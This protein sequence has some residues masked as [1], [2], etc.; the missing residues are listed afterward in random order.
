MRSDGDLD[1]FV[2]QEDASYLYVNDGTGVFA[3]VTVGNTFSALDADQVVEQSTRLSWC[4]LDN[5]QYIDALAVNNNVKREVHW[6]NQDGTF[7]KGTG[8][9]QLP[10][11]TSYTVR[12]PRRC[13]ALPLALALA[14]ALTL[15]LAPARTLIRK[16]TLTL[17]WASNAAISTT[18]GLSMS[19]WR[20]TMT[21]T[22]LLT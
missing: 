4:D 13:L 18:M 7:T 8:G 2:S 12:R 6:N 3:S 16:L 9:N 11:T 19:S 22:A 17:R 14:P 5:D 1:L 21:P 20:S 15:T 10:T